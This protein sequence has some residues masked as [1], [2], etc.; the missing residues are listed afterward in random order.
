MAVLL[1]KEQ[2]VNNNGGSSSFNF[3]L[4]V[5]ENKTDTASNTSNLTVNL[6]AKHNN[7]SGYKQ[8]SG[9]KASISVDSNQK[10]N[11]DVK[12]IYG[13]NYKLIAVWIGDI[14]HDNDGRKIV[15]V[16]VAYTP[17]TSYQYASRACTFNER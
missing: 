16:N 13:S 2:K 15:S 6:Y 8:I 14:P 9:P 10:V 5:I 7:N 4:E 3:K 17:N 1:T 11:V 12:E